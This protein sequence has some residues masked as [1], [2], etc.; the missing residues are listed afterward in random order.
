MSNHPTTVPEAPDRAEDHL[1]VRAGGVV[2]ALPLPDVVEALRP[3]PLEPLPELPPGVLGLSVVRGEPVPVVDLRLVLGREAP[4]AR[5]WVVLRVEGR[6]VALVVDAVLGVER[7]EPGPADDLPPLL[8]GGDADVVDGLA[9]RDAALLVRLRAARLVPA[10]LWQA[11]DRA[12]ADPRR[13][14]P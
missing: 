9:A 1:L 8:A 10:A 6:R 4:A 2:G 3:L 11:L 13:S 12:A 14:Q 5:R 7:L